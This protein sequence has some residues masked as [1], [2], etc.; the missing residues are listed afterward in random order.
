VY[1][2]LAQIYVVEH[3]W[4]T[5]YVTLFRFLRPEVTLNR[6]QIL[7]RIG[8]YDPLSFKLPKTLRLCVASN[9]KVV[10][11]LHI[12]IYYQRAA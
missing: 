8:Q 7:I 2:L 3:F 9:A 10:L 4:K 5:D 11:D 6:D 12:I 1:T